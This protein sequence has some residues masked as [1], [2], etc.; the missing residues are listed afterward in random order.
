[1]AENF[2]A[3]D[4]GMLTAISD[5]SPV[6]A[7]PDIQENLAFARF[8]NLLYHYT[9]EPAYRELAL[10]SARYI[11]SEQVARW[12]FTRSGILLL[13]DEL[14]KDPLH[15]TVRGSKTDPAAA[16]LFAAALQT[17]GWY[18]RVE[19]WDD[20]E[21]PLPNPDVQ[22]PRL[23]RAAVFVCTEKRCSLPLFSG[24]EL[25]GMLAELGRG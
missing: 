25:V 9:G 16:R 4:A 18:K 17:P 6:P 13:D 8:A 2:R 1:M 7:T 22:Y 15:L 24:A 10:H 11:M 5:A 21:G 20:A 3:P 12:R 19:W 14:S 23:Q